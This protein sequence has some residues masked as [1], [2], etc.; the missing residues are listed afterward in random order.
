[1]IR[2][3]LILLL[4]LNI[5]L[6]GETAIE[7]LSRMNEAFK[8]AEKSGD[9]VKIN[10]ALNSMLIFSPNNPSVLY[11]LA[12]SAQKSGDSRKAI[13][14]LKKLIGMKAAVSRTIR[15]DEVFSA[16]KSNPEFVKLCEEANRFL[17]HSGGSSVFYIHQE[18][19]L[20]PEG[21]AWDSLGNT[22]YISSL[23]RR[24]IVAIDQKGVARDF[25][26]EKDN[27]L[28]Q[29]VGMEV[30][31]ARRHLWVCSGYWGRMKIV[32]F[33]KDTDLKSGIFQ[34]DL[35]NGRLI[36]SWLQT[37][38]RERFFNDLVISSSGDVYITD[39]KG[40]DLFVISS[41]DR[42]LKKYSEKLSF[43]YP[44]GITMSENGKS[45]FVADS[46][47]IHVIRVKTGKSDILRHS[48]K[49]SLVGVDGL[50]FYRDS[51]IAHQWR[52]FG[53]IIK[54]KLN[55][56]YTKVTDREN[57]EV[58]NPCFNYPTTGEVAG[59][60]YY[61]IAN[62]QIMEVD[63]KGLLLRDRLKKPKIMVL[64]LKD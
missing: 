33:N 34:Y 35:R 6:T 38:S 40:G 55:K 31:A 49:I 18:K 13:I 14:Y 59:N 20:M 7:K 5:L 28:L 52:S 30:D 22:V 63:R 3:G 9:Y 8:L 45:L 4:L 47:G 27:G 50:A 21:V 42:K 48:E 41:S 43:C 46:R 11:R 16:L 58:F 44:N 17:K 29:V 56:D 51:L 2:N 10:D 12:Q 57:L 1:M 15:K 24:K 60:R 64:D 62:A 39:T 23:Y 25:V 26:K 32:G 37:D 19:D 53:G 54:Y 61:Y 36:K